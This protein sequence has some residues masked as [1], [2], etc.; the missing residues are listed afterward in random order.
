MTRSIAIPQDIQRLESQWL[1]WLSYLSTGLA[2]EDDML[3]FSVHGR[4][5][6]KAINA[7]EHLRLVFDATVRHTAAHV[8]GRPNATIESAGYYDRFCVPVSAGG[9]RNDPTHVARARRFS[10]IELYS[11]IVT[12]HLGEHLGRADKADLARSVSSLIDEDEAIETRSGCA[13]LTVAAL[14]RRHSYGGAFYYESDPLRDALPALVS[15]LTDHL[16]RP[17]YLPDAEAALEALFQYHNSRVES[18]QRLVLTP[19]LTLIFYQRKIELLIP[20]EVARRLNSFLSEWT[21]DAA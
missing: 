1:A 13:V 20:L 4:P 5:T 6:P 19:D 10:P 3:P 11:A 8:F 16:S 9:D 18:R 7:T 14:S 2:L 15:I 21:A 12:D 17:G